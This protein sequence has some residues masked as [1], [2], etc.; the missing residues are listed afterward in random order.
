[1]TDYR[2]SKIKRLAVQFTEE[3]DGV[4]DWSTSHASVEVDGTGIKLTGAGDGLFPYMAKSFAGAPLDLTDCNWRVDFNMIEG[5]GN[6][7]FNYI[8]A[9]SIVLIDGSGNQAKWRMCNGGMTPPQWW[10]G[11][12]TYDCLPTIADA[13]YTTDLTAVTTIR[14]MMELN[15]STST[16][17]VTFDKIV[18]Y[19]HGT[20]DV[21]YCVFCFDGAH[22]AQKR[23]GDYMTSKGLKGMFAVSEDIVGDALRMTVAELLALQADGH[24]ICQYPYYDVYWNEQTLQQHKDFLTANAAWMATQG[25]GTAASYKIIST[26]SGGRTLDE[27]ELFALGYATHITG[28][29][30]SIIKFQPCSLPYAFHMGM[31]S[32]V[33]SDLE[34]FQTGMNAARADHGVGAAIFHQTDGQPGSDMPYATFQSMVDWAADEVAAGRLIVCTPDEL[35]RETVV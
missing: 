24:M 7:D 10:A 15:T 8:D 21:G 18:F 16:P 3:F 35:P 23:A 27:T 34:T 12:N 29:M 22:A 4:N 14:L 30:R 26:P 1:M 33:A 13:A 31:A 28:R 9:V 20:T 25:L 11:T 2:L 5:S 32:G 17:S 19:N 6:T